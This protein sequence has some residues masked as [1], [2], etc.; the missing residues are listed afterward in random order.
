MPLPHESP[1]LDQLTELRAVRQK[2]VARCKDK[3]IAAQADLIAAQSRLAETDEAL[4]CC[5]DPPPLIAY[6]KVAS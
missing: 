6:L 3:V 1:T 5:P 2:I 4:A